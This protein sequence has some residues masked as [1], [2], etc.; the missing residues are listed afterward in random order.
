MPMPSDAQR[1]F[2]QLPGYSQLNARSTLSPLPPPPP[3]S[4]PPSA[5][6]NFILQ[7]PT[8][9]ARLPMLD[10]RRA[11]GDLSGHFDAAPLLPAPIPLPSRL[12]ASPISFNQP[13]HA[14][15]FYPQPAVAH[16]ASLLLPEYSSGSSLPPP[17]LF[18]WQPTPQT[19]GD[20]ASVGE[21]NFELMSLQLSLIVRAHKAREVQLLASYY[22]Q[23]HAA[24]VA[25]LA[26]LRSTAVSTSTI[27][28]HRKPAP[29]LCVRSATSSAVSRK[30]RSGD[31]SPDQSSSR[32]SSRR[33]LSRIKA[34]QKFAAS[35]ADLP[36]KLEAQVPFSP[37]PL[38]GNAQNCR[39]YSPATSPHL[40]FADELSKR[41]A[42]WIRQLEEETTA[43]EGASF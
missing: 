16:A 23:Q 15:F 21:P 2:E 25:S 3:L 38:Y 11:I 7:T 10:R 41:N 22:Q 18:A 33:K 8:T 1:L 40:S 27:G 34:T 42:A 4:P 28:G 43:K 20:V 31:A 12:F 19:A 26:S 6:F 17:P 32:A 29:L 39:L 5:S 24:Y 36:P 30:R 13:T 14:S 37:R 35:S 9:M